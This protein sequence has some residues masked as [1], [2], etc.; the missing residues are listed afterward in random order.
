M[1]D[2][3]GNG[4]LYLRDIE[5]E[6]NDWFYVGMAD[7]TLSAATTRTARSSCCKART[8]AYDFD[9][10]ADARLAFYVNG[11]FNER[12]RLTASADTRDEPLD[13]SVQQLPGQVAGL[14][15]PPHR[16]RLPLPDL[17]RRRHGRGD[18]ADARQ[19][20]REGRA[21]RELWR[22][23]QLPDRLHEQRARAGRPRALRRESALRVAEARRASASGASRSTAS[24]PSPARSRAARS[25]AARAAR[26]TS[27]AARTFS[28]GSE[29]VR[30]EYRD[31]ASGLVTGV[32]NLTPAIDYDI[33]YLQGRILLTRAAELD[34]R[35]RSAGARRRAARR[36]GVSRRALRVHAGLR[37][38][39][40]AV[41]RRARPL[42][43]RRARQGRSHG[44]LERRGRRRQR[45]RGGGR[46]GADQLRF[47]VQAAR[48]AD[49]GLHLER[50][51]LRRRRFR[52]LP[53]TTTRR[54]PVRM[55][56]A[57]AP[58]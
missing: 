19:V 6:R 48:R 45:P 53:A 8:A 5:L 21:R 11:K 34:A 17:R 44:E 26:C 56:A 2:E 30:I 27:C 20:L 24:R 39:R 32:I 49:R 25:S 4:E 46:D 38:A 41:G 12:W 57:T 37:G 18:G 35:G 23:G 13:G 36:R 10:S 3:Q 14:A 9:S 16:S 40:R 31:R 54:S 22:V 51:A 7:L 50:R 58:T 55:P 52:L 33:D 28:T 42:L 1:L 15:V 47:V 43:V 29:R